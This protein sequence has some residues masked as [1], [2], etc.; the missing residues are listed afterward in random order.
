M[1]KL[2]IVFLIFCG[3]AYADKDDQVISAPDGYKWPKESKIVESD[4]APMKS[5]ELKSAIPEGY[6]DLWPDGKLPE[7]IEYFTA[8]LNQ[9]GKDEL[10]IYMPGGSGTGGSVYCILTPTKTGYKYIGEVGGDLTFD[11]PSHDWIQ[12][13]SWWRL[14]GGHYT[15]SLYRYNKGEYTEVRKELHD[16]NKNTVTVEIK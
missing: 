2:I 8:D 15:R 6:L 7:S 9:D 11:I 4:L 12:I 3:V 5:A 16:V 10:F 1:I 13:E 14:G